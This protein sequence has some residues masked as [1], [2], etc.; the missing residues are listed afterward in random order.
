MKTSSA[1]VPNTHSQLR[2]HPLDIKLLIPQSTAILA[3][4]G[5]TD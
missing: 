2:Q 4:I 3:R 1:L 5:A